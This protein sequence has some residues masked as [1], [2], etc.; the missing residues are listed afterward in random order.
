MSFPTGGY[1]SGL[2]GAAAWRIWFLPLAVICFFI[3]SFALGIN[4][5]PVNSAAIPKL[6]GLE[7][8]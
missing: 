7:A 5:S 6:P 4:S 2:Y 3:Q 8:W 1:F